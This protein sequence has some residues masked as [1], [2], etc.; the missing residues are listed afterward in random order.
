MIL[1]HA[2]ALIFGKTTTTEF[3]ATVVGTATCNPHDPTRTPGGSSSGS[4][5]AVGDYQVPIALGTQ[6]GGSVIRPASFNG[7]YAMKPTWGS[8]TREGQKVYSLILDTLGW[9]GR[10]VADLEM[11]ADVFAL[12]DD[13]EEPAE[14]T[15]DHFRNSKVA[16]V[17]TMVWPQVGPGTAAAM[18]TAARILRERGVIVEEIEL[19]PEFDELPQQHR[20]VLTCDGRTAFLPEYYA[21]KPRLHESLVGHV[22]NVKRY[23]R[24]QQLDAFDCISALR[25]KIDDIAGRYTVIIAPSVPDEAPVGQKSTGSAAFNSIWTVRLILPI[26]WPLYQLD[27]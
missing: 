10:C 12:R 17:K 15:E 7:V 20:I 8:V 2:G 19:P 24:A 1:R 13:G 21:D 3:A 22:D 23:T 27:D 18:N 5:A 4:G 25:P 6:T 14:I 11:L 16:L 9:Y 26:F